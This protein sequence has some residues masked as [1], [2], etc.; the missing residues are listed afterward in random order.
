M[1][2]NESEKI[3]KDTIEYANNEIKRNKRKSVFIIFISIIIFFVLFSSYIIIF[4]IESSVKYSKEIL[5]VTI[6]EDKGIDI[7]INLPNYKNANAILVKNN[8]E[9]YDLYINITKTLATELFEDDDQSNNMIRVGN[10]IIVD[11]QSEHFLGYIPN[12][13]DELS[14]KNIYY[15]NKYD[16]KIATMS[17]DE[18]LKIEKTLVWSNNN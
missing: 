6:P 3:I 16:N 11:F 1:K 2:N 13:K 10:G 14:I 18:L 5:N 4:K 15:I 7:K 8:D 17:D 9:H 12:D